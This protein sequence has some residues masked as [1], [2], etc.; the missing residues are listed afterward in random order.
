MWSAV[1]KKRGGLLFSCSH[2]LHRPLSP[3]YFLF[4]DH[5]PLITE[6]FFLEKSFL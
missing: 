2:G 1:D 4:T 6:F 5:R 3:G